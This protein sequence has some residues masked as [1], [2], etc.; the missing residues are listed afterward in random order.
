MKN[1]IVYDN[2][3]NGIT[4][5]TGKSYLIKVVGVQIDLEIDPHNPESGDDKFTLYSTDNNKTYS[6]EKNINDDM[7]PGDNK[8]SLIFYALPKDLSYSLEI[9]PG[10][11]GRP[12]NLFE[13]ISY[14]QLI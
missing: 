5:S 11:N 12:Y 7:I 1:E 8:V 3:E 4:L 9:N 6:C 10:A 13:N 2:F 14:E